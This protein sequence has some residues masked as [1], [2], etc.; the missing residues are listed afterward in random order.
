[1]TPYGACDA[2]YG[3][4]NQD[5]RLWN[6]GI[7]TS[8]PEPFFAGESDEGAAFRN[9][10]SRANIFQISASVAQLVIEFRSH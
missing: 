6:I 1:L 10:I 2:P 5:N 3:V 9:Y 8:P 7:I 4:N